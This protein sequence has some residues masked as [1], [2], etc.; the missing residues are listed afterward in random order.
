[1]IQITAEDAENAE[2]DSILIWKPGSQEE[3]DLAFNFA[4]L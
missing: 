4:L 3:K 2:E 1:M